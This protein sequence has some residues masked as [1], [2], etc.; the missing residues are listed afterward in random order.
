M[1]AKILASGW[2]WEWFWEGLGRVLR[3]GW[4]L[5][6]DLGSFFWLI[7][8]CLYLEWSSKALLEASGSNFSSILRGLGRVWGGFWDRFEGQN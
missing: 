3:G 4:R 1:K 8:S 2:V 5:L 6:G 7:F